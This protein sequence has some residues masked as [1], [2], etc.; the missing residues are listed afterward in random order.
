MTAVFWGFLEYW[1]TR[2]HFEGIW[3]HLR[4]LGGFLT[5]LWGWFQD[6]SVSSVFCVSRWFSQGRDK[7]QKC[8]SKKTGV[9]E[10]FA[11]KFETSHSQ[12]FSCFLV[13]WVFWQI[14][15]VRKWH[16]AGFEISFKPNR[17]NRGVCVFCSLC[18]CENL[19]QKGEKP[20]F[21][22]FSKLCSVL[23]DICVFSLEP[24]LITHIEIF[25]FWELFLRTRN[26]NKNKKH[27]QKQLGCLVRITVAH[28]TKIR[29]N[30]TTRIFPFFN[31]KILN[32]P[33]NNKVDQIE[34]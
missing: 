27:T 9:F 11:S 5:K 3:T 24:V 20:H 33:K 8:V 16:L 10:C 2:S 31:T 18:C 30:I 21:R 12:V 25:Y 32:L 26:I 13:F 28:T 34:L 15:K 17:K 7:G 6:F 29:T 23:L 4:V 1:K 22:V 14:S 19:S